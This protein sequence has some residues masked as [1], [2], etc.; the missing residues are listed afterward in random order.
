MPIDGAV[1]V[2]L[3]ADA[4]AGAGDNG[5]GADGGEGSEFEPLTGDDAGEAGDDSESGDDTGDGSEPEYEIDEATGEPKVDDDGNKIAKTLDQSKVKQNFKATYDR[6]KEVDPAAADA[7]RKTHFGY[8]Q[9][10][11]AFANPAAAV[12]AKEALETYGGVEGIE[13]LNQSAQ[14]F[15]GEM[16]KFSQ[17]DPEFIA[18][19]AKDDPEG[20][21]KSITAG[22]KTLGDTNT[23]AYNAALA[24]IVH[25][26]ITS[27]GIS[28]AI[29]LA[30]NTLDKVFTELQASGG[31]SQTLFAINKA[32]DALKGAYNYTENIKKIADQAGSQPL[33]DKEKTLQQREQQLTQKEQGSRYKEIAGTVTKSLDTLI[34]N[35]LSVY[36]KQFPKITKDQ[37]ADVHA[38]VL[39]YISRQLG[40]NKKYTTQLKA[41]VAEGDVAKINNYVS[42]NVKKIVQDSSKTVWNR[43]GFGSLP[44]QKSNAPAGKQ[45]AG[46]VTLTKRPKRDDIDFSLPGAEDEFMMG[47]AVLKGSKRRVKWNWADVE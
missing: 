35:S 46:V 14:Q 33:S 45:N 38:G 44:N 31:D 7:F 36:Y 24:P 23:Q 19:L 47:R 18:Q 10:K 22:L 41:L 16:E 29:V 37:K 6:L 40:S 15:A 26:T 3:G 4:G 27:S 11:Q 8:E 2:V 32:F 13:E 21:S 12:Q 43:R 20:F 30:A 17:G 28:S 25:A 42:Q 5:A 34:N 1:G 9:Y 39:D